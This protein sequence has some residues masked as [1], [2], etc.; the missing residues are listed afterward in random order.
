[1]DWDEIF[2]VSSYWAN[3]FEMIKILGFSFS[4]NEYDMALGDTAA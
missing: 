3:N 2:R 4:G 1:M